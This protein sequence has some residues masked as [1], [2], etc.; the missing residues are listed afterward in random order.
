MGLKRCCELSVALSISFNASVLCAGQEGGV[1]A[2][3]ERLKGA[4]FPVG[5]TSPCRSGVFGHWTRV[6]AMFLM[7]VLLLTPEAPSVQKADSL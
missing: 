6:R 1:A 4:W 7:L 5:S 2:I 3:W